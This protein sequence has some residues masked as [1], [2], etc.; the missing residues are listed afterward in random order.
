MIFKVY[1]LK[2]N[3]ELPQDYDLPQECIYLFRSSRLNL[4]TVF[5]EL[6]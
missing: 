6:V 2:K 3:R 4:I 5:P 1:L